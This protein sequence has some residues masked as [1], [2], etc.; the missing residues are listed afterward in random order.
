MADAS[1]HR[2]SRRSAHRRIWLLAASAVAAGGASACATRTLVDP[3]YAAA[4]AHEIELDTG[5]YAIRD[6][7]DLGRL[8]VTGGLGSALAW[9]VADN[10]PANLA[11]IG[12]ALHAPRAYWE[13]VQIHLA[14]GTRDCR[15]R[16]AHRLIGPEWEF[17]YMCRE[18]TEARRRY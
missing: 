2:N 10:L 15:V 12:G 18:R 17:V 16:S 14:D 4:P 3:V 6:R 1:C 7:P 13:A 11:N 9:K 8:M 5:T